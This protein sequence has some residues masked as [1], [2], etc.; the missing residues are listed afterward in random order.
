MFCNIICEILD[1]SSLF[2]G[3]LIKFWYVLQEKHW[4]KPLKL[5]K[6]PRIRGVLQTH[7]ASWNMS[8]FSFLT[9]AEQIICR[10]PPWLLLKFPWRTCLRS[11]LGLIA[12]LFF[13]LFLVNSTVCLDLGKISEFEEECST[14]LKKKQTKNIKLTSWFRHRLWRAKQHLQCNAA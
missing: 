1:R 7:L 9:A 2:Q 12:G 11:Y 8:N 14:I 5:T 13:E 10:T 3:F 4:K 6:R